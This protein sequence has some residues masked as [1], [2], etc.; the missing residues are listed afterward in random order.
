MLFNEQKTRLLS[1]CSQQNGSYKGECSQY[2]P[3]AIGFDTHKLRSS[4]SPKKNDRKQNPDQDFPLVI[5]SN[6]LNF[7]LPFTIVANSCTHENG[8]FQ[9]KARLQ[10]QPRVPVCTSKEEQGGGQKH[11]NEQ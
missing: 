11:F 9:R 2:I 3:Y 4:F 10:T 5:H 7:S 1:A 6:H 8:L